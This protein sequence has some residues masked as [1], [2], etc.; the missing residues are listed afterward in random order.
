MATQEQEIPKCQKSSKRDRRLA[1]MSRDL[2]EHRWKR[3]VY[4]HWK[5][6]QVTQEDYRDAVCH[7]REK[8]CAAKARLEF[9]LAST[10]KDNKKGFLKIC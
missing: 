2:L 1:W 7:Y 6:G 4:G 10:V 5:Q 8:I 3:K 9:K